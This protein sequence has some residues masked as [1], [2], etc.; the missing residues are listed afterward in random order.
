MDT[1][2]YAYFEGFVLA[3]GVSSRMGVDKGLLTLGGAPLVVRTARL[4]ES[5]VYQ[6][7]VIGPI[8]KYGDMQFRVVPDRDFGASVATGRSK[9][10]LF[11]IATALANSISTWNLIVGCDL[12]YLT[13]EWVAWFLERAARSNAQVVV[14]QTAKG[15]EPLAAVYRK[16][17]F[18]AVE[19]SLTSGVRRVTEAL[20]GV[21]LDVVPEEEWAALDPSGIVL[22]NMNA[23][24][25][26]EEARMWW[27]SRTNR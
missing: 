10:P 11:G 15:L 1:E 25:E 16:D 12:P 20:R 26:Y 19:R 18:P 27:D 14:P 17:C 21:M 5:L 9:G 7:T 4:I 13:R 2:A 8:E 24:A 22:K 6:V 23:P 3:G